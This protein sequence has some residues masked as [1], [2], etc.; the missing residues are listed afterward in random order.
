MQA[1]N[2]TLT[3]ITVTKVKSFKNRPHKL[4]NYTVQF[5]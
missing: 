3:K 2:I 5:L 1:F 4:V